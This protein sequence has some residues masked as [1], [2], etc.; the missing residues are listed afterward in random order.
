MVWLPEHEEQIEK[1]FHSKATHGLSDMLCDARNKCDM[2]HW[3]N[4]MSGVASVRSGV[5]LLIEIN[6]TMLRK[7]GCPKM[8]GACTWASI[9]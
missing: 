8:V 3:M 6:V 4:S 5:H 7:I 2:P 9:G 1:N